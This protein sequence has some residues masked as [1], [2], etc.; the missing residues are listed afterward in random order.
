MYWDDDGCYYHGTIVGYNAARKQHIILYDDGDKERLC[1]DEV[2]HFWLDS[3]PPASLDALG[4]ARFAAGQQL[5]ALQEPLG[6]QGAFAWPAPPGGLQSRQQ[7]QQQP[8]GGSEGEREEGAEEEKAARG[9][10]SIMGGGG[11]ASYAVP[12]KKRQRLGGAGSAL[13]PPLG[14]E[15]AQ[16]GPAGSD[17][18]GPLHR[19]V[20][21]P[22]ALGS[23]RGAQGGLPHRERSMSNGGGGG[24]V[25]GGDMASLL[26]AVESELGDAGDAGGHMDTHPG[27]SGGRGRDRDRDRENR[28]Y[29]E[30]GLQGGY[31]QHS[32]ADA[33]GARPGRGAANGP[34]RASRGRAEQHIGPLRSP[35][36]RMHPQQQQ[37]QHNA[38]QQQGYGQQG[39]PPPLQHPP[40]HHHGYGWGGPQGQ[41]QQYGPPQPHM[42]QPHYGMPPGRG[43]PAGPHSAKL[44]IIE[45]VLGIRISH[46]NMPLFKPGANGTN[47]S[48]HHHH[49]HGRSGSM[50]APGGAGA[51][52]VYANGNVQPH[53]QRAPV[54]TAVAPGAGLGGLGGAGSAGPLPPLSSAQDP[55][56]AHSQ[57]LMQPGLAGP[58]GLRGAL[59]G[60][61]NH[62]TPAMHH[63]VN[64]PILA[65][66]SG[67]RGGLP[68]G[69]PLMA[70]NGGVDLWT[71]G[72]STGSSNGAAALPAAAALAAAP[73]HVPAAASVAL[74]NPH[75]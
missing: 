67:M 57:D 66:I 10:R 59:G 38:W 7:Q 68:L 13:L 48:H 36:R 32:G 4:L 73:A 40:P 9:G 69:G 26:Q 61:R 6:A 41:P 49:M 14:S 71:R 5:Q 21:G 22:A 62:L 74:A 35:G 64:S 2:Q 58:N 75:I 60:L 31:A 56:R 29:Q 25:F 12:P 23:G 1:L 44:A 43:M 37:Q 19:A 65:N 72:K 11:S 34:M 46:F 3:E 24:G 27:P 53:L 20:S 70:M 18:A 28:E 45:E 16:G 47:N 8:V 51:Q 15:D 39:P 17:A 50:P 63:L 54:T 33:W 42:Q 55:R 30:E 52:G